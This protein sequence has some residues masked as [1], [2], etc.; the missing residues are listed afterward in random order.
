MSRMASWYGRRVDSAR[1]LA[2]SPRSLAVLGS[3]LVVLGLVETFT[4]AAVSDLDV[5]SAL[6]LGLL[7]L[8]STL[9]LA[10]LGRA[11]A[12]LLVTAASVLSLAGFHRLSV[13]S[14][15]AV[16]IALFRLG[17]HPRG[18]FQSMAIGLAASFL[19]LAL[20]HLSPSTSESAVLTV[21]LAA[22]APVAAIGGI[23]VQARR[24]AQENRAARQVIS[25]TLSEHTARG[26][27]ARV[28]RELHDIVA[29]HIS[30]V[31][32]QA[33]AAR[34]AVPGLPV[35]GAQRL[36]AIG[37]TARAA[38]VEMRQ[39]LGVL[40]EGAGIEVGD[41]RPQPGLE[42]VTELVDEARQSSASPTRLILRGAPIALDPNV[43]L[44]AYRIVQ[45]ALSNARRHAP[46]AAVDVELAY[47]DTELRLRVRDNGPGP[48]PIPLG[49]HGLTGMQERASAIGAMV[50]TG[51]ASGGGYLVE[52]ALPAK[53]EEPE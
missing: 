29:H 40:R 32:V 14:A 7:A 21:V 27:R 10:L 51:A 31:A 3:S 37:D 50:R 5:E 13:A 52:A 16:L 45:E 6:A 53:I 24:E 43:E 1:A 11:T 48:N 9:P 33:E 2:A 25:D 23:A 12:A 17:R 49:G 4:R 15:A 8:G 26:E 30:M 41:R 42:Q 46:G 36:S 19:V 38:L 20:T 18:F 39:L 35:A 34:F 47:T 44:V 28:A 22:L